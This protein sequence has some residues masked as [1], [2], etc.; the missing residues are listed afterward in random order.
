MNKI[1]LIRPKDNNERLVLLWGFSDVWNPKNIKFEKKS[2]LATLY[3]YQL[4][5]DYKITMIIDYM[6]NQP[7][8]IQ[9]N[10][11]LLIRHG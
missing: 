9:K 1:R 6:L 10:W 5:R 2:N 3:I 8:V 4:K 11:A 7:N